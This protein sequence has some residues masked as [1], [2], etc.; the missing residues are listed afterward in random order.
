MRMGRRPHGHGSAKIAALQA[1]VM[2]YTALQ[3]QFVDNEA[4]LSTWP[5][6]APM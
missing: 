1:V 5:I 4:E 6:M 2:P 3:R